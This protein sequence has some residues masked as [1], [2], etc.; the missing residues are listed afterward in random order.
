MAHATTT[1]R[2][3]QSPQKIAVEDTRR[4]QNRHAPQSRDGDPLQPR[5]KMPVA[6]A[7][8]VDKLSMPRALYGPPTARSSDVK[9]QPLWAP[10]QNGLRADWPQRHSE[11]AALLASS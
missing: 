1:K 4:R 9:P 11:Y 7:A 8:L 10:S 3:S 6:P 2:R 5:E